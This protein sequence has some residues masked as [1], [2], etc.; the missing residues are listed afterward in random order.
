M[1]GRCDPPHGLKPGVGE[2]PVVVSHDQVIGKCI[3]DIRQ[4][5]DGPY[6]SQKLAYAVVKTFLAK[7]GTPIYGN[8][9][10]SRRIGMTIYIDERF[11][12]I[13]SFAPRYETDDK[14]FA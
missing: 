11:V 3:K 9:N 12:L 14:D 13:R 10:G 8:I 6:S 5:I 2:Y 4:H 7:A 1:V